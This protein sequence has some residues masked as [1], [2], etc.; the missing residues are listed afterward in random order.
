MTDPI[1]VVCLVC[2]STETFWFA[3]KD[4]KKIPEFIKIWK[5]Q[6]QEYSAC[7]VGSTTL[8]MPSNEFY[9]VESDGIA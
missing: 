2:P 1:V 9:M 3:Y 4:R 7:V 6:N 5:E 8:S